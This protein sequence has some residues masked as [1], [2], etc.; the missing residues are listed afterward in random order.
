MRGHSPF[1]VV[2]LA[3]VASLGLVALFAPVLAPYDPRAFAGGYVDTP[4]AQHLLGTNEVGQDILSQIIWG[5]RTSLLVAV[6][7]GGL[8][9]AIGVFV[10]L[11]SALVG[12]VVDTVTTRIVDVFLAVPVLPLLIIVAALAGPNLTTV[13]FVLALLGWPGISRLVRSQALSVRRRGFVESARGFGGGHLYILRCHM[14]PAVAP[15][16]IASFIDLAGIAIV[17]EAGLAFLGLA[18]PLAISWGTVLNQALR[19]PGLYFTPLWTWWVLPAGFAI[20]V[21]V[22][23]F[24]FLGIGLEPVANRRLKASSGR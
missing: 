1:S 13:I 9:T 22:L 18:D 20:M 19:H 5:T 21:A 8:T 7:G 24:T 2:G 17:F 6:F 3:I 10:G 16:V 4:S 23:G 11:G 14:F 15:L 12:G